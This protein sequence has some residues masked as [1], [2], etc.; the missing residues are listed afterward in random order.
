MSS[1]YF[2]SLLY[3]LSFSRFILLV[4][5]GGNRFRLIL[6]VAWRADA[7][8]SEVWLDSFTRDHVPPQ[9]WALFVE[10]DLMAVGAR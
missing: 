1:L 9:D 3:F 4:V 2:I 7:T 6:I 10:Y 8:S 5:G